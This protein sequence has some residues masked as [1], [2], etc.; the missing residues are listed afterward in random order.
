MCLYLTRC[1][2]QTT[3][4]SIIQVRSLNLGKA[5][6]SLQHRQKAIMYALRALWSALGM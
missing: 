5:D 4:E 1:W 6:E 3:I 2:K